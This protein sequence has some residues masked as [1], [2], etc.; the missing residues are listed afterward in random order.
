M[1]RLALNIIGLNTLHRQI[2][3]CAPNLITLSALSITP[4]DLD[5]SGILRERILL[6][7]VG[8]GSLVEISKTGIL[9]VG[10]IESSIQMDLLEKPD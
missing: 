9:A 7:K 3:T 4:E 6:M 10:Q 8:H 5:L 2:G 1:Y